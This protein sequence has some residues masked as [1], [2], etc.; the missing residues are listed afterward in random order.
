M[1]TRIEGADVLAATYS[2]PAALAVIVSGNQ[3][4]A[5]EGVSFSGRG[6][7][8]A[9]SFLLPDDLAAAGMVAR[10]ANLDAGGWYA[11]RRDVA[12]RST[13][14]IA[15]AVVMA[16]ENA[17]DPATGVHTLRISGRLDGLLN[18]EVA[19]LSK[20]VV[21]AREG[22]VPGGSVAGAFTVNV[23]P[24]DAFGNASMKIDNTVGSETYES[25]AVTFSSS[26]AAVTVPPGVQKVP[27]GGADFGAVAADMDGS[28]TIAVRTVARDLVTGTG[29]DAVTG[30]FSGS[31]TVRFRT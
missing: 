28:A 30:A 27:A 24:A 22:E 29:A 6:V 12:F 1:L 15:G 17:I 13:R 2:A 25:V 18:V 7:S 19:E 4:V 20:F 5:L 31:V 16:A 26:N 23:L 21:A 14:P 10:A 3:A 9:P 11:G 8:P